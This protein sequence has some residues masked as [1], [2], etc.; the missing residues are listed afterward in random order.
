MPKFTLDLGG[1]LT[2]LTNLYALVFDSEGRFRRSSGTFETPNASNYTDY[3]NA[4]TEVMGAGIYQAD[5]GTLAAGGP[6]W[7]SVRS[8]AGTAAVGDPVVGGTSYPVHTDGSAV[9]SILSLLSQSTPG[10][11][12]AGT[13]GYQIGRLASAAVGVAAPV[14]SSGV[15][16]I[17]A[18]DDYLLADGRQIDFDA[19][20]SNFWPNL[21]G[22][23]VT[24]NI[25][26]GALVVSGTVVTPTGNQRVRFQPVG[27]QTD[28]LTRGNYPYSVKAVLSGGSVVTLVLGLAVWRDSEAN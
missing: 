11:F 20:S 5:A 16:T 19:P 14:T 23:A 1:Q 28:D 12:S 15:V 26:D 6:Y 21:T 8:H 24:W 2:G 13:V 7:A 3:A 27:T 22:A 17:V 25:S 4:L 10:S 9:M 18:G